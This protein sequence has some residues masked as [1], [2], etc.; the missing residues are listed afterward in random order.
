MNVYQRWEQQ[1]KDKKVG[2]GVQGN[3]LNTYI[4]ELKCV[5]DNLISEKNT[6]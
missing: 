4:Q 3:T 6:W 2:K 1:E 5:I